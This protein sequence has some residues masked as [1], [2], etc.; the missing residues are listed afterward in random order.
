MC[1]YT[2]CT[3]P[4][5]PFKHVE[6]QRGVFKDKVWTAGEGDGVPNIEGE[7]TANRFAELKEN[8]GQAEELILPGQQQ[9]QAEQQSSDVLTGQVDTQ[10]TT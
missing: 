7:G 5:C 8:E 6:G 10:I 2:P 3:K 9:Q 4:F 1:R